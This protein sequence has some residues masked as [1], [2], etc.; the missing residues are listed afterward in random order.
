[1][2][3]V[4]MLLVGVI[5]FGLYS[6]T[7]VEAK[8]EEKKQDVELVDTEKND[9]EASE[10]IPQEDGK[11]R[12]VTKAAANTPSTRAVDIKRFYI[13]VTDGA[14]NSVSVP[15]TNSKFRISYTHNNRDNI[16]YEG[17]TNEKGEILDLPSKEIPFEVTA[18]KIRYYLGNDDRGYVQKYNKVAYSYV[19][20]LGLNANLTTNSLYYVNNNVKFGN[21][22]DKD[23]YFY[24][25]QATR[26]N[27]YF[28][29][30]VQEYSSAV[31]IT[32]GLLPDTKPFEVAP[33][34]INFEKGQFV[35]EG[36]GF[37]RN[38]HDG[39]KI[40]DIIIGDLSSK[41]FSTQY[42]MHNVMHEWTHWNLV[43]YANAPGGDYNGHFGYNTNPKI[44][45][46]EG[47]PLLIGDLFALNYDMA[48]EDLRVQT[49]KYNGINRLYGK[50]T[51]YTVK[52]VLYDLVDTGSN[53]EAFSLSQRYLD[54]E[55][56]DL[57]V[58]RLNSGILHTVM[59]EDKTVTLQDLLTSV[60]KKYVRTRSDK[61][62]FAKLLE[63]NGLSR[64]GAFTL[65]NAGNPLASPL[66]AIEPQSDVDEDWD[67]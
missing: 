55:M 66:Q 67:N 36:N 39:S 7:L 48:N 17:V 56:T 2:K 35:D 1:M 12:S 59:A 20:T 65:D 52:Q 19:F 6:G 27:H 26:I 44:S 18:L 30:S 8:E 32:N 57:E 38:G 4:F 53:D 13:E 9:G 42:L 22:T 29:R 43:R 51:I 15:I 54:G 46:K 14:T 47:W 60:E 5:T 50:S 37:N 64:D 45:F 61:E 41:S 16:L 62:K 33:I 10:K 21:T 31:K 49:D 11:Q 58:R 3:K 28:D 23:T 63:V 34:N 40:A 24:N 25:F